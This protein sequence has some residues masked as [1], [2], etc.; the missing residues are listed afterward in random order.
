MLSSPSRHCSC[1]FTPA[2]GIHRIAPPLRH[3]DASCPLVTLTSRPLLFQQRI[4]RR[5]FPAPLCIRRT[6]LRPGC[7]RPGSVCVHLGN[8][9]R[10]ESILAQSIP[11]GR[12]CLP[13]ALGRRRGRRRRGYTRT[14]AGPYGPGAFPFELLPVQCRLGGP[15]RGGGLH[16]DGFYVFGGGGVVHAC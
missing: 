4:K 10:R 8:G 6:S 3:Y 15:G 16:T 9:Y 5:L 7:S 13:L 14:R 1:H 2:R 11:R 12:P